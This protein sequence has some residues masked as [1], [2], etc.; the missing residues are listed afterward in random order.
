MCSKCVPLISDSSQSP[1][2]CGHYSHQRYYEIVRLLRRR[3]QSLPFHSLWLV[4]RFR[5]AADL[6][7]MQCVLCQARHAL[8]PRWNLHSLAFPVFSTPSPVWAVL[9]SRLFLAAC[10][11]MK[12]IGFHIAI[13]SR[14]YHFTL[15]RSVLRIAARLAPASFCFKFTLAVYPECAVPPAG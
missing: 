3:H 15:V 8:R 14:L 12:R 13:V 10:C 6:P 7:G 5:N 9:V 2:L 4:Y 11:E 1:S